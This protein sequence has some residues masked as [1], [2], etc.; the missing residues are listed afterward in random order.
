MTTLT[1]SVGLQTALVAVFDFTMAD[2]MKTTAGVLTNFKAAA[3]VYGVIPL[4]YDAIV[5]DGH[6]DVIAVSDDTG[7]S[8]VTV[9]NSVDADMWSDNTTI[10]LKTLGRTKLMKTGTVITAQ[11]VKLLGESVLLTLANQNGNATV[12]TFRLVVEY[13]IGSGRQTENARITAPD[14]YLV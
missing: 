9:G 4:P 2:A 1:H 14:G 10:D 5:M 13:V 3:G 6:F 8:T 12:G 7:T 11:S